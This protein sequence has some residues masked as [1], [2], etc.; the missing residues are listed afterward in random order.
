MIDNIELIRPL[1]KFEDDNHFY[2]VEIIARK[3]DIEG[4]T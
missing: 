3:K 2:M 1:L 4:M